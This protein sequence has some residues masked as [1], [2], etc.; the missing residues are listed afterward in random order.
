MISWRQI[1]S[2]SAGPIFAIFT[3]NERFLGVD[4][5]FGPLFFDVSRD[6]ATTTDFVQKMANSPLS[7]LWHSDTEWDIAISMGALIAPK[8]PVYRVKIS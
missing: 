1:I 7:S 3:S 5:R 6:V 8:M 4:D 2:R